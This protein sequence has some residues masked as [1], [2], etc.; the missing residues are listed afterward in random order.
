MKLSHIKLQRV[1]YMPKQLQPGTLYASE[2]YEIASHLCACGCGAKVITPLG[3]T[4]WSLRESAHGPSLW[5]SIG[6]WQEPCK[7]HY[8]IDSGEIIWCGQWTPEQIL[9]GR[10]NEQ[11]RAEAYYRDLYASKTLWGRIQRWI[12]NFFTRS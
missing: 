9:A 1:E 5:P 2:E 6:N 10:R 3:P 12:R 8:I 11:R 7:S 4:D